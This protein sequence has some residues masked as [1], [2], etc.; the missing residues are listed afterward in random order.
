MKL[1][2]HSLI[3]SLSLLSG[4]ANAINPI[5]SW[6]FDDGKNID[7][8]TGT[9][10]FNRGQKFN[11][12]GL[13]SKGSQTI[14]LAAD[15]KV[16]SSRFFVDSLRKKALRTG[17]D[18]AS[19]NIFA[20]HGNLSVPLSR[21]SGSITMWIKPENWQGNQKGD[22]RIFLA[23]N[24]LQ[25]KGRTNE[26]LIYK[27]GTNNNLVFLIGNNNPKEWSNIQ[28]SIWNWQVNEWHFVSAAWTPENIY[29]Y[30]D[31]K[32]IESVRK[33]IMPAHDYNIL[34]L[35]TRNWKNEGGLTVIDDVMIFNKALSKDEMDGLFTATRPVTS[36]RKAPI[37]HKI[38]VLKANQD[39]RINPFE[40]AITTNGTFNIK[41]GELTK[42][43]TW[44]FSRDRENIYFA[45]NTA[46]PQQNA[47]I[48]KRDGN[49]WEDESIELHLEYNDTKWQFIFNSNGKFYDAKN[50]NAK[51]NVAKVIQRHKITN[52]RWIF[53]GAISFKD[54]GIKP[55]ENDRFY[56][57]IGRSPGKFA[58]FTAISPLLRRFAD[59]ANFV[60]LIFAE[61]T[62]PVMFD[63]I[64]LPGQQGDLSVKIR[65]KAQNNALVNI[66]GMDL[67]G[68][69]LAE[70]KINAVMQNGF[71]TA[72]CNLSGLAKAGVLNY[73][74]QNNNVEIASGKIQYISPEKVKLN[75]IRTYIKEQKLETSLALTPPLSPD[76]TIIHEIKDKSGTSLI[77]H[78]EKIGK[79]NSGKF[80]IKQY[81]ELQKLPS[82]SHD[83]YLSF[84]ENGK[85]TPVHHQY[86]LMP[87]KKMPWDDFSAGISNEVPPQWQSPQVS[88]TSLKCSFQQ[89]DFG[90]SLLPEQISTCNTPL[91]AAPVQF[92]INGKNYTVPAKFQIIE[93]TPQRI[94]FKTVGQADKYLFEV[95]G[96]VEYDGFM[97]LS[98]SYSPANGN[99]TP[100]NQ[101]ALVIPMK[102]EF[103][104]LVASFKPEDTGAYS[105]KL[106]KK[107]TK[108]LMAHPVFW[109]GDADY[110][111]YWGADNMRG[112]H[113]YNT[114]DSLV[115]TPADNSKGAIATVKI[116]DSK[117]T[118]KNKRTFE[119][120]FQGTPVKKPSKKFK[121]PYMFRG[122]AT[123]SIT[124]YHKIFNYYNPEYMDC[125]K[126]KQQVKNARYPIY[127]LYSCIYG[128]SPFCPEWPYYQEKW[129]SSPPGPGVFKQDFPLNN[130]E[131]RNR[132]Y[133][134][135]GCVNEPQFL[136]WQLYWLY[137]LVNNK[138]YGV[139]DLY[140]DMAY[141]RACDNTIHG[142]GWRDDFGK[143]RMTYPIKANREFTKRIRK[144]MSDKDP[145]GCL[146]YHP[147][148][149]PIPPMYG[150]ADF[151][152]DGEIYVSQVSKDESYFNIFTPELFQSAYTGIKSGNSS[153]YLSQLNRAAVMLNPAR[154]AYW[155]KKQKAPE[156]VR[157]VRHFLGYCLLHDVRPQAGA[158]IYN[159]GEILEKQLYSIG[160][161]DDNFTFIPY[162]NKNCPVKTNAKNVLV[163]VYKFPGKTL[164][165]V[166]NDS[167]TETLNISLNTSFK[168]K[169]IYNLETGKT[170][171]KPVVNIP[172]KGMNLIVFEEK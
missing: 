92:K 150:L 28:Y 58:G 107:F 86:F 17:V 26:L 157:A 47:K 115:I 97:N 18:K 133:W 6:D 61:N 1:L 52:D 156:A 76:L 64:K 11:F 21:L 63:Y 152:V 120:S 78:E 101:L 80:N 42:E 143:M 72:N 114:A 54:L 155:R 161:K 77:R 16:D 69:T 29:L 79:K 134:A 103:S 144:I 166:L 140:F 35:G 22:F 132:G 169:K 85:I 123:L 15:T 62:V 129:I 81:L 151:V 36:D 127:A 56:F 131:A 95:N 94:T 130:E 109:F 44:A 141:P 164:A 14:T 98:L 142:C 96:Y 49:L 83:Y 91:L 119:F 104:K 105:G 2:R 122:G 136:N 48:T 90:K 30:V 45:C 57:T 93:K 100:I 4:I 66:K 33:P 116:V 59:R 51:W 146:M 41:S 65:F 60:K 23:A 113:I 158:C 102:K 50:D 171:E 34:H 121:K 88:A 165:V 168:F 39:G 124:N 25:A 53:E 32:M 147:S 154:S 55:Q 82:G 125:N 20:A 106:Y 159:E 148:G 68:R 167:K 87:D 112:S 37:E 149:E 89:Y 71:L 84:S 108:D 118:L 99:N 172:P 19:G 75:Y 7:S 163:S 162:W 139:K 117:F 110:G 10:E 9:T 46:K 138:E 137:L 128:I 160:Y 126:L 135:F 8:E 67:K 27:N 24:D 74:V 73:T 40:Y 38:G 12:C 5:A 43:N 70:K 111:I 31:G 170:M 13:Q 145:S 3:V 153:I